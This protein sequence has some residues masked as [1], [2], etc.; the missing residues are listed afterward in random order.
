MRRSGVRSSS[1][2][3]YPGNRLILF[4]FSFLAAPQCWRRFWQGCDGREHSGHP[5]FGWFFVL[6]YRPFSVSAKDAAAPEPAMTRVYGSMFVLEAAFRWRP[7][8]KSDHTPLGDSKT[9]RTQQGSGL[10]IC[11]HSDRISILRRLERNFPV[12]T[13]LFALPAC[14][15]VDCQGHHL[16]GRRELLEACWCQNEVATFTPQRLRVDI[17]WAGVTPPIELCDQGSAGVEKNVRFA[18]KMEVTR[19]RIRQIEGKALRKLRHESRIPHE[20]AGIADVIGGAT[21]A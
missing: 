14:E 7:G 17:N 2:P 12:A 4:P 8:Q 3:P 1:S 11:A 18:E 20:L 10:S 13:L 16:T 9:C 21:D 5:R 6:C 19:E 15:H